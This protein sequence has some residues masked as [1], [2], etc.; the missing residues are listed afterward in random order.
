MLIL[1]MKAQEFENM[2]ADFLPEDVSHMSEK[3]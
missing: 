1:C 3:N 2:Q